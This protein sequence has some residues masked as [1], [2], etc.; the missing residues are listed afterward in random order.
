MSML[1][2][3][4]PTVKGF[5]KILFSFTLADSRIMVLKAQDTILFLLQLA[6]VYTLWIS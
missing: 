5:Y 4:M 6:M 1:P 2:G 3:I